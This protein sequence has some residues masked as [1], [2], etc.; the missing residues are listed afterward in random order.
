MV[1][2]FLFGVI[3]ALIG[4]FSISLFGIQSSVVAALIGAGSANLGLLVGG[5]IDINSL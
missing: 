5:I 1:Y 3:F 2:S 4:V